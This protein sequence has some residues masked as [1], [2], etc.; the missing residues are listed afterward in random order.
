MYLLF[1]AYL[2]V[3]YIQHYIPSFDSILPLYIYTTQSRITYLQISRITISYLDSQ[4][5]LYSLVL[6]LIVSFLLNVLYYIELRSSIFRFSP[7]FYSISYPSSFDQLLL[8]SIL[9]QYTYLFNIYIYR[10]LFN[11]YILLVL[12][13]QVYIYQDLTNQD[14]LAS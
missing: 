13:R 2:P 3:V 14:Y 10:T 4:P 6:V 8:L 5:L 7:R 1:G 11:T 12:Y 9:I